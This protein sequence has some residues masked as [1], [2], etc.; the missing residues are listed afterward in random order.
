[1]EKSLKKRLL[2][3]GFIGLGIG[4]FYILSIMVLN[5]IDLPAL[6]LLAKFLLY[7]VGLPLLLIMHI[8]SL[9]SCNTMGCLVLD[10]AISLLIY[11]LTGIAVYFIYHKM[12][13]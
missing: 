6:S 13:R 3:A 1:M 11:P 12:K 4:I 5:S 10:F 8:T 7:T 2:I 9:F